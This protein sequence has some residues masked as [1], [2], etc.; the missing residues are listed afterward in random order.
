MADKL[1]SKTKAAS[2]LT[3]LTSSNSEMYVWGMCSEMYVWGMCSS[4]WNLISVYNQVVEFH[5]PQLLVSQ[6]G[7]HIVSNQN[8]FCCTLSELLPPAPEMENC[9]NFDGLQ[10]WV[11]VPPSSNE[12]FQC[13]APSF[14]FKTLGHHC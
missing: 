7:G 8:Y 2:R 14:L 11:G 9:P 4:V 1:R 5:P 13:P 3:L 12:N 6:D 10:I